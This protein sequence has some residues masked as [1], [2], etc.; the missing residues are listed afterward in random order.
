MGRLDNK[1][2]IITGGAGGIGDIDATAAPI[3][4]NETDGGFAAAAP[5]LGAVYAAGA[6]AVAVAVGGGML[7]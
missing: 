2:A 4:A 7:L 5:A 6:L 3:G 1:V